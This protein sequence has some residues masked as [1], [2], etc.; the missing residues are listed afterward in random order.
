MGEEGGDGGTCSLGPL[1]PQMTS[2]TLKALAQKARAFAFRVQIAKV[3]PPRSNC[4]RLRQGFPDPRGQYQGLQ[5][6]AL[7]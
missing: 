5:G 2:P 6:S 4:L 3:V 7:C 1:T